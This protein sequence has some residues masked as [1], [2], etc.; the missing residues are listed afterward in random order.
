VDIH[1]IESDDTELRLG[2][3]EEANR[4]ALELARLWT[5]RTLSD[6]RAMSDEGAMSDQ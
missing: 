4:F 6:Q 3:R 2:T 5:H 1:R